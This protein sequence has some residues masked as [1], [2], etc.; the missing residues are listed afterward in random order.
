MV[1][2]SNGRPRAARIPSR[3]GPDTGIPVSEHHL[4]PGDAVFFAERD[5]YVDHVGLYVGN[6]RFVT[7][8]PTNKG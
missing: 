5:G 2:S 4:K 7:S 6:G 3:H 1:D 8:A